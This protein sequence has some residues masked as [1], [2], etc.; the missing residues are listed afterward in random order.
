LAA[1]KSKERRKTIPAKFWIGFG[2]SAG[3]LE[4]LR[5][6]ARN[7]PDNL[8]VTYIVAQHMAPHHKSMLSEIIGRETGMKVCDVTDKLL[9]K[10]NTIYITPPNQNIIVEKKRLRLVDPSKEPGAPKPSVD[11]FLTSLAEEKTKFAI[12]IIL[13]GTGSDGAKGIAAIHDHGGIVIAQDEL[14]AKYSSMPLAAMESG[15]VDLVMSPEEI[16][17]QISKI[18]TLPRDLN[19]LRASPLSLDAVSELIQLLYEQTKV[20]FRHYK[21]ATFQRRVERRMAAT[22]T[23]RLEE[24]VEVARHSE[25]EVQALFKDLLISVTS[26]FRDPVEFDA[27]VPH[28]ADII[29]NK[30][31]DHI[32][33]WVPGTATGEEAY[34]LAILFSE[35][36]RENGANDNA[37]LQI[38]AT[39]IDENAIE[40]ARRG[41][42]PHSAL[43]QVPPDLIRRYFD[44][45]PSGYSVKKMLREKMVFSLHNIAQDPPFVKVDMISCRN[46]LIYFQASLQAEVFSRF[47]YSLLPKGLLFLGK[48]EAVSASEALFSTAMNDKHIFFQ[49]PSQEKRPP[50]QMIYQRPSQATKTLPIAP[51]LEV[52]EL[53]EAEDR[54]ESL[55]LGLGKS[56]VLIDSNLNIVKA[57]GD[58]Q[59]YVGVSAG[60]IDTKVTSLLRDPFRQD[61]QAAAPGV[62]RNQKVSE[63]FTRSVPGSEKLREKV[64]IYPIDNGHGEETIALAVFRE[65]EEKNIAV[66][67]GDSS[68]ST[69]AL[70]KQITELGNE[71][72]IAKTNLQQTVEELETTNEELQ[73]LNE[74]LQSSNEELQSTNE[75]LETS[76]E[77]LQSTNEELSTVNEELQVNAQQLSL[78][79]QNLSSILENVTI[80]LLVVDRNLNITNASGVS[81]E[82]FGISHDLALPHASRCKLRPG[83]PD[84]VDSLQTALDNGEPMEWSINREP[85]SA[86]MKIVPHFS[87]SNELLGAIV[88]VIDNTNE[89]KTARDE[90]QLIFDNVPVAIMVRD[91]EGRII[92]ANE[93]SVSMLGSS[94]E[95]ALGK[96]FYDYFDKDVGETIQ[97][98]DVE[99]LENGQPSIGELRNY[100]QKSGKKYWTRTSCI[101]AKH[102]QKNE[103]AL[104]AVAQDV[105]SQY[106][107]EEALKR[108]QSR[109]DQ[110]IKASNVGIWDMNLVSGELYWSEKQKEIL[111][112]KSITKKDREAPISSRIHPDD[113]EKVKQLRNQHFQEKV[114]YDNTF[115]VRRE[116]GNYIWAR[117]R[118]QATWDENGVPVRLT[119]TLADITNERELIIA[120]RERKEQL[121]LAAELSGV[122]FW[123]LDLENDTLI[124]SEQVHQI[125]GTSSD[126]FVPDLDSAIQFYHP[127]DIT[128][129]Q[130]YI[131]DSMDMNAPFE[132]EA[133]IIRTDKAL[134]TVRALGKSER[135]EAGETA[136]IFGVFQ[137][138]T[139][140]KRKEVDL[141]KT[142]DEL[143]RSNEELNRFSYVCSHDMKEPVRMIESMAMLLVD[144]DFHADE[145]RQTDILKRIS[146]N[147]SRLR[148]IIDSLLAYSRIDAKIDLD[149]TNLGEVVKEILDSLALAIKE[150]NAKIEVG[151]MPVIKGA[152]VHFTQLFQN[153]IGNALKFSDKIKPLVK[154]SAMKTSGGWKFLL[155]DNGPGIPEASRSDIF[156][157]FSRLQRQDEIEGSGLGLSIAQRIVM[158]YGG[159]IECTDSS[160]GGAAFE[161]FLPNRDD[162]D[163]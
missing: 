41:F 44:D 38:F 110:A 118:A 37:K 101:P 95:D 119:G 105:T 56:A 114:P 53:R 9:P 78:V 131:A 148:A 60:V 27:L 163:G 125:H 155:E 139:D 126:E 49:R 45:V 50:R 141:Q 132:F 97:K 144:P 81:D 21:T 26:F 18:I 113:V 58:F 115:R 77:E 43:D 24:Y 86:T 30:D 127:D 62:M 39:D 10:A 160:L 94:K 85:E 25:Q 154:I 151:A 57:Y 65:W 67:I 54:L 4:A 146:I 117:S 100:R 40:V 112:V 136:S 83:F 130:K 42:Y 106:E 147:T 128:R 8:P 88:I 46:L 93:N 34:S 129:V 92:Q 103:T 116:S 90:L 73:A 74:E 145:D 108:S 6:L 91:K 17:A 16:G 52:R 32:R 51:S 137:D 79:N 107:A 11:T 142:L 33:V 156:N 99:V 80:P 48:S 13:S 35:A 158:Q 2:A 96:S 29:K 109:L 87:S 70:R 66:D 31:G 23:V 89:L 61:I 20:N 153:L 134:R 76:N 133:R 36:M 82:F 162:L 7:L 102:P 123:K 138:I 159:T 28:I 122:G 71:L 161:I 75:E 72:A 14:T 22:K 59:S 143:A 63:G 111:G 69:S 124:W 120:M 5:G 47:H 152:P 12:G 140:E 121:E 98:F 68:P 15:K 64:S 104:Y 150:Q 135:N 84:L 1:K 19:A 157:L 149:D 55:I 3:G